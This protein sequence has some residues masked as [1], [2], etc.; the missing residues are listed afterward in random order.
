MSKIYP[1]QNKYHARGPIPADQSSVLTV[2]KKSSMAFQ[3]TD[4][5]SVFDKEGKLVFRVDNYSRKNRCLTGALV[6]MDGA[7]RAL[8]TLRPQILSMHDQWNGFEGD[9][10]SKIRPRMQ[11]F[12][13]RRRS[14][15]QRNDAADIFRGGPGD[16]V[17][18]PDFRIEGCFWR[19][20]CKIRDG[21]GEVAA[22]ISRKKVNNTIL[23]SE[24]VFSLEVQ[25]GFDCKLIMAFVVLMDRIGR[26]PFAPALCS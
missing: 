19:R 7:G 23:L 5:F 8:F 6:L 4:G 2:W 16:H 25:P 20:N 24:D 21:T 10:G 15:L 17:L 1:T 14:I 3:G 18:R 26:K 11:S 13:M 22:E 12:S 9:G